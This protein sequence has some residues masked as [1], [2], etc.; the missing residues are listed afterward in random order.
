MTNGGSV[1]K[2]LGIAIF[3]EELATLL[4]DLRWAIMLC[5]ALIITDLWFGCRTSYQQGIVVRKSRAIRR[6]ANKFVDYI[7][8]MLVAA[9][10]GMVIEQLGWWSHTSV[11]LCG[12][13]LGCFCEF[14][15][16]LSHWA[17]L[18]GFTFSLKKFVMSMLARKEEDI[19]EAIKEAQ[20]EDETTTKS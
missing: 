10:I 2:G 9:L 15:S 18:H 1:G 8:Y 12:I 11:A 3:S 16:I 4:Y 13:L 19:A 20:K 14:E 5:C 7:M 17:N 6:T